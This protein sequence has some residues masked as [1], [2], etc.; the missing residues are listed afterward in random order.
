MALTKI[1]LKKNTEE[2][3][4][5]VKEELNPLPTPG[6]LP[7]EFHRQRSLAGYSPRA[8]RVWRAHQKKQVKMGYKGWIWGARLERRIWEQRTA[9]SPLGLFLLFDFLA[10][11]FWTYVIKY[12]NFNRMF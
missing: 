8:H 9:A 12:K 11:E 10:F 4:E 2:G 1:G 5:E 6:F 7:G 3:E